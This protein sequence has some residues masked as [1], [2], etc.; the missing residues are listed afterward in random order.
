MIWK[1]SIALTILAVSSAAGYDREALETRSTEEILQSY[2]TDFREDPAASSPITFGIRIQGKGGGDWH[3]VV[4][5]KT[6]GVGKWK[7][8]LRRG[9]PPDPTVL[10]TLDR[11][12]LESI[13]TGALSALTAMGKARGSDVAPMDIEL[14]PGFQPDPAFFTRFIPLTFHFW[15]RGVPGIVPFGKRYSRVVHGGNAVALYYQ[16]GFRSAWY[17][18]EKGQHINEDPKDQVNEFPSMFVAVRGRAAARIGGKEMQI[19]AGEMMFVPAGVS[20][21][22]WNPYEE[23]VELIVLMVGEGA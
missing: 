9:L 13:D 22:F 20:H 15:T 6:E 10:Y 7:V 21:E 23:P 8:I 16:K 4:S 2:V 14:M 18:L 17:Q 1:L 5:G 3:V 19:I 11:R 12:T